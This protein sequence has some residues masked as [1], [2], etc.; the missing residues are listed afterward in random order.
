MFQEGESTAF[1]PLRIV[2]DQLPEFNEDFTVRLTDA[3]AARLGSQTVTTVTIE[4]ND[5]PNG[6]FGRKIFECHFFLFRD[7]FSF[8]VEFSDSSL[9]FVVDEPDVGSTRITFT[10]K[11]SG[12]ST[13]VVSV[14]YEATIDGIFR[15]DARA[16]AEDVRPFV[17]QVFWLPTTSIFLKRT[18]S[19]SRANSQLLSAWRFWPTMIEKPERLF[20]IPG[21]LCNL[22]FFCFI[23]F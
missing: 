13:G 23:S 17:L 14:H 20:P 12:G 9:N 19:F 15:R 8:G 10:L 21:K 6:A 22:E 4:Q 3:G 1:V 11:R 16:F 2:N 5:D 18:F 7:F